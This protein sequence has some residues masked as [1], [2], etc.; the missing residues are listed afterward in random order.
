SHPACRSPPNRALS[1][2]TVSR[3]PFLFHSH[4]ITSLSPPVDMNDPFNPRHYFDKNV[5]TM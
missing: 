5:E 2:V 4:I 1:P 3:W